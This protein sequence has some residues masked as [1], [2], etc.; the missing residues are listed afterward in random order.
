MKKFLFFYLYFFIVEGQ[1][2][3]QNIVTNLRESQVKQED[4]NWNDND[5]RDDDNCTI[6]FAAGE[7]QHYLRLVTGDYESWI[8]CKKENESSGSVVILKKVLPSEIDN[9]LGKQGYV[10]NVKNIGGALRVE[11]K[12]VNR[13]GILY[14]AY[15][16]LDYLGVRWFAPG[17]SGEIVPHIDL[18]TIPAINKVEN[19]DYIL[20]GFHAF[21]DRGGTDL[22]LWMARN[23]LNYWTSEESN[24]PLLH[25]LGI[26]LVGGEHILQSWYLGGSNQY[27][28]NHPKFDGDNNLPAD[29][30]PVSSFFKG[31]ENKDH[32]LSY[33]E[34]H[35]EWYG[36]YKGKRVPIKGDN[37]K[38]RRFGVNFCTTNHDALTEFCKNA[39]KDLE[40]GRLKDASIINAWLLDNAEWCECDRCKKAGTCTDRYLNFI[41]AYDKAIKT[42]Q[43]EGKINRPIKLLM[44]TYLDVLEPPSKPLP[45]DFDY[46]TCIATFYPIERCYVH[47]MA[48][49]N[50]DINNR[51]NKIL[52]DWIVAPNRNYKGS[53]CIGEYYN[54]SRYSCLPICFMNTMKTDIPYYYKLGARYF[55]YMHVPTKNWGNKALTNWQMARQTWNV[56]VD[57][58]ALW[59]DYFPKRYGSVSDIM[60]S[61][62]E[63]LE[64]M[65][66]NV[67]WLKYQ[68]AVSMRD[69]LG[70]DK[71]FVHSHLGYNKSVDGAPC[72]LDM[73]KTGYK[74]RKLIDKALRQNL[75]EPVRKRIVE[76]ER[77]FSYGEKTLEFYDLAEQTFRAI[78]ANKLKKAKTVLKYLETLANIM[79]KDTDSPSSVGP[80]TTEKNALEATFAPNVV[81]VLTNKL[82][83]KKN[84]LKTKGSTNV[85]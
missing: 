56:D 60:R 8:I 39:V 65:M 6:N 43:K 19:P 58:E 64:T 73:R 23:R 52:K 80:L 84:K 17:E 37:E 75:S 4:V 54:V 71:R 50:C 40:T 74:C 14:G 48:D 30:Y 32:K 47:N 76:D 22:I 85:F 70:A 34:A 1:C 3:S 35:P 59:Q 46:N 67:T 57:V 83:E 9:R 42:A 29:P 77:M 49:K 79:E 38:N 63:K 33:F 26:Q 69:G 61:F 13:I 25:K 28:Y 7:L 51:Y 66:S 41:Y 45:A 20:R 2:F 55:Q 53:V 5:F 27:P 18:K 36:L 31:D 11:I 21:E 78:E 72:L 68:T 15:D 24:K 10:L 16:F 44:L 82:A 12:A 62:Y 81:D